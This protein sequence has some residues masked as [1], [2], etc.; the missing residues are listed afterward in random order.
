MKKRFSDEQFI[1]IINHHY[2]NLLNSNTPPTNETIKQT[3]NIMY[4]DKCTYANNLI[5]I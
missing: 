1:R 2:N 4:N 5:Q 3:E